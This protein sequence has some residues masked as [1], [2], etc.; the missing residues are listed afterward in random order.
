MQDQILTCKEQ[1]CKSPDHKFTWTVSEQEF[2]NSK[3]FSAPV[4]CPDC[5]RRIKEMKQGGGRPGQSADQRGPRQ[6]HQITCANCGEVGEV[7]FKPRYENNVL[8]AD[9]YRNKRD[10][11]NG[12]APTT[13]PVSNDTA[14]VADTASDDTAPEV[15]ST[16][17]TPAEAETVAA[18]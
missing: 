14:A 17:E 3:G 5:R 12:G 8:C 13:A 16:E 9:C 2:Y 7:P 11:E 18:E 10:E 1:D 4:R 15:T 6:M